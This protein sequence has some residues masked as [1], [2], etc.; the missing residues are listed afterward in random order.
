M[1]LKHKTQET[2]ETGI[3]AYLKKDLQQALL[4]FQQVLSTD[5][6]DKAAQWYLK[7]TQQFVQQGIP[8]NWEEILA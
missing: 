1:I 6:Q 2:F 4:S 8:E 7:Q 3:Q 5:P